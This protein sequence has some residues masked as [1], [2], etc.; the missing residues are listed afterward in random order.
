MDARVSEG[1]DRP[2]FSTGLSPPTLSR[3]RCTFCRTRDSRRPGSRRSCAPRTSRQRAGAGGRTRSRTGRAGSPVARPGRAGGARR[4]LCPVS[5][6][7][8][9][10]HRP[11]PPGTARPG[12]LATMH[13]LGGLLGIMRTPGGVGTRARSTVARADQR[14]HGHTS[15]RSAGACADRAAWPGAPLGDTRLSSTSSA[16][17][18]RACRNGGRPSGGAMAGSLAAH[19]RSPSGRARGSR[20][21]GRSCQ[22]CTSWPASVIGVERGT[23]V[24]DGRDS[25]EDPRPPRRPHRNI[26]RKEACGSARGRT[27]PEISTCPGS[28][29]AMWPLTSSLPCRTAPVACQASRMTR[30]AASP[31]CDVHGWR[32][33]KVHAGDRG[34]QEQEQG[35]GS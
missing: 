14:T 23:R 1:S 19:G 16:S 29:R 13:A 24:S 35:V 6:G 3:V 28:S 32:Q 2:K 25:P 31:P 30:G 20:R 26:S 10:G 9:R 34:D 22:R 4:S 17:R 21:D 18:C 12:H 5:I 15:D 8:A 27:A 11:R 7:Y 33:D